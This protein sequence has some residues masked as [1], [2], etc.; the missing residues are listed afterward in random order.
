MRDESVLKE[1][2]EGKAGQ[3]KAREREKDITSS[4]VVRTAAHYLAK[5]EG[6]RCINTNRYLTKGQDIHQV[7]DA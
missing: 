2:K 1:N 7:P 3:E 4:Q 6:M 5:S